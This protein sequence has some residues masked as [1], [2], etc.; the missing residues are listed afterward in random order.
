MKKRDDTT[1][2]IIGTILSADTKQG[3]IELDING[4]KIQLELDEARALRTMLDGAI[5]AA[6]SDTLM[7]AFLTKRMG[8][9]DDKAADVMLEFRELRQGTR[10]V[11]F[12][13]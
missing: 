4:Q 2:I 9:S 11:A 10:S 13:H 7:F 8:L 6:I 3:I 12:P 1:T 5:E